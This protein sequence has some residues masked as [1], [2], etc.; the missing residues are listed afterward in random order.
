MAAD[1]GRGD[2]TIASKLDLFADEFTAATP[3]TNTTDAEDG[4]VVADVAPQDVTKPTAV[5]GKVTRTVDL[6]DGS[7]KQVF[8]ANTAD[9]LLD[10]MTTAQEN[11]TRKIREQEFALKRSVRAQADRTVPAV[12]AKKVLT[13]DEMFAIANDLQRN[14]DE[15]IDKLIKAKTGRTISDI[16][17][18]IDKQE[19]VA[20]QVAVNNKFLAAH[21][22]TYID[23]SENAS[24]INKFLADEKLTHNLA[25]LEYAYQELTESGL[26]DVA[27]VTEDLT[28]SDSVKVKP[29]IRQKPM[30]TG[31]KNSQASGRSPE[32]AEAAS[33]IKE[34]EVEQ[35]Y[36]LPQ[37]EARVL[38]NRLI[39]RAKAAQAR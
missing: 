2:A 16:V 35:I 28:T 24:R 31:L 25:N 19:T 14:P 23:N 18:Y 15:A 39:A 21:K 27:A 29:H 7:G 26:L 5:S 1:D 33:L 32:I 22:D 6:G 17:A 34:S 38:M 37:E 12:S 20:A 8:S 3:D 13:A 9:E 11:A 36:K 10:V 30:S 4:E